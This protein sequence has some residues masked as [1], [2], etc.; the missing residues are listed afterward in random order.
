MKYQSVRELYQ[1]TEW[2]DGCVYK[3]KRIG[4]VWATFN[5]IHPDK[6]MVLCSPSTSMLDKLGTSDMRKIEDSAPDISD[7]FQIV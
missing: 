3:T 6:N 5:H 4:Y 2:R 1:I 7:I